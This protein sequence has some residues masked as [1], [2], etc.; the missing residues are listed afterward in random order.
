ML[1]KLGFL[2]KPIHTFARVAKVMSLALRADHIRIV[3]VIRG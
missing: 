2:R 3:R 1:R